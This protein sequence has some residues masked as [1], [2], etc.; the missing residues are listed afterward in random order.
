MRGENMKFSMKFSSIFILPCVENND[1]VRRLNKCKNR[2][3]M[4]DVMKRKFSTELRKSEDK[5]HFDVASKYIDIESLEK[6]IKRLKQKSSD[7]II[8]LSCEYD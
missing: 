2:F 1:Y 4:G 6:S 3:T 8:Q 7:R 5:F